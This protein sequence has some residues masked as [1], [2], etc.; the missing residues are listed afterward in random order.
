MK[1][2]PDN[3]L[4]RRRDIESVFRMVPAN[5][6]LMF[7]RPMVPVVLVVGVLAYPGRGS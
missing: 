4:D 1:L 3:C 6:L 2:L 7:W 5:R